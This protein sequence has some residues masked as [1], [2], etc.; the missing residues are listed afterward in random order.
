MTLETVTITLP[1]GFRIM[2]LQLTVSDEH[3]MMIINHRATTGLHIRF[4]SFFRDDYGEQW[5]DKC[6]AE[7]AEM[8]TNGADPLCYLFA[9]DD[10]RELVNL[11][12]QLEQYAVAQQIA[13]LPIHIRDHCFYELTH[14]CLLDKSHN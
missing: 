9:L 2:P 14:H 5:T 11:L 4:I 8:F 12:Y 1:R 6:E 7:W 3:W 10:R 13:N